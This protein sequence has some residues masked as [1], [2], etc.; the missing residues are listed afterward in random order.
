MSKSNQSKTRSTEQRPPKHVLPVSRYL[1]GSG[2]PPKF[3]RLFAGPLPIFTENFMHNRSE[4]FAQ[5]CQQ[6][7]KQTTIGYNFLGGGNNTIAT[8][9][10]YELAQ[11]IFRGRLIEFTTNLT[12]L[13]HMTLF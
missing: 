10:T 6:T 9:L 1:T 11:S 12:G 8:N 2:L 5:S 13:R 3:N 4:A 7:R